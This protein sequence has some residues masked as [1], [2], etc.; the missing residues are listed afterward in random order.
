MAESGSKTGI[1]VVI[2]LLLALVAIVFYNMRG[3]TPRASGLGYFVDE[4]NGQEYTRSVNDI[5]PV[6]GPNGKPLVRAVK[7]SVD[8]TVKTAYYYKFTDDMKK[9]IEDVI[10]SGKSVGDMEVGSGQL[11][12]GPGSGSKWVKAGT[13]EGQTVMQIDLSQ[14]KE[15][16]IIQP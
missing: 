5:P 4:D 14:G 3:S 7:Y 10:A 1:W 15:V 16:Q 2:V 6:S 12:R 9:K 11:V 13:A 8:G